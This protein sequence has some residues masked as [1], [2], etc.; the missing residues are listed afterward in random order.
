MRLKPAHPF[1][2]NE[3]SAMKKLVKQIDPLRLIAL[4]LWLCPTLILFLFG[5]I[6]LWQIDGFVY[7]L[8]ALALCSSAGYFLQQQ[9]IRR[10][11][12]LLSEAMTEPNPD[13]PP[14]AETAWQKVDQLANHFDPQTGSI[15][16]T[17][18]IIELGRQTLD[19][20]SHCYHP[21]AEEPYLELT[22]PHTLLIIEQASRD[23]R[24]DITE[25][26]PFSDRFTLGDLLRLQRWKDKAEQAI[27]VYRTGRVLVDPMHALFGEIWQHLRQRSFGLARDELYRWFLRAYIRKVGYYAIDLYSGRT[28][29]INDTVLTPNEPAP[30]EPHPPKTQQPNEVIIEPLRFLILGKTNAGKSSLI[31]VLFGKLTTASDVLPGTTQQFTAYALERE[32]FEQALIFDSPGCDSQLFDEQQM[33]T[34]ALSADLIFWVTAANRP[35]RQDERRYLDHLRTQQLKRLHH[36]PPPIL[37]VVTHID[38]LRPASVWQPPY[39]LTDPVD[40]K[41]MNIRAAVQFI[42]SDLAIPIEHVIPVC[43]KPGREYNINDTLWASILDQQDIAMRVRLLRCLD[44]SKRAEDWTLLRRQMI[45][46]GRFLWNLPKNNENRVI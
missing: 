8:I 29:M 43:L 44:A 15:E 21:D 19:T 10:N 36:R 3:S 38:L 11:R 31:N 30:N 27:N 7:W 39:N 25:N 32:G 46:A 2:S 20:V 12:R 6:W 5:L 17:S 41:A 22:V 23:L 28:P 35:D 45:S 13:W 40:T 4:M 37:A 18:W 34:A 42:A 24:H 26:I 14:S 33:L 16:N 9:L 1:L